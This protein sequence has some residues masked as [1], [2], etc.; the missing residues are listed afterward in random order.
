MYRALL[1]DG[2]EVGRG[3]TLT[4]DWSP[5][6]LWDANYF[7]DIV[8]HIIINTAG[9]MEIYL[10]F[11]MNNNWIGYQMMTQRDREEVE[12]FI[13]IINQNS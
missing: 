2:I 12:E 9:Y 8:G 11:S 4:H 7:K 6:S 13:I 3:L 10:S 5:S 1:A